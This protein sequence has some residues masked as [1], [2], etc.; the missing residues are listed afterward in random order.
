M[1][2]PIARLMNTFLP[3]CVEGPGR[4]RISPQGARV[5][6]ASWMRQTRKSHKSKSKKGC[7]HMLT[8]IWN[9]LG[10]HTLC[11]AALLAVANLV[12]A[13]GIL[14]AIPQPSTPLGQPVQQVQNK[15]LGIPS[16]S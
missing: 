3:C 6:A 16:V 7:F 5:V 1:G 2:T 4:A 8:A 9:M 13:Q 10:R 14:P 11:G 12:Q 15:D